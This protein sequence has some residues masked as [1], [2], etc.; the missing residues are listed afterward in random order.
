MTL[1]VPP[2]SDPQETGPQRWQD[3]W[4]DAWCRWRDRRL[5]D[6]QF[7]HWAA[8]FA[9]TRPLARR[10]AAQLFDLVAGF[11]YSQT[12]L[13][14][15]RL[16][17][18]D[19]LAQGPLREHELARQVDLPEPACRRLLLAAQALDLVQPRS[20]GRWGLGPLG[21]TLVDDQ[22]I[23]AMV[24]HHG[25]LYADL[26]DPVALL[27]GERGP[28]RLGALWSY[29]GTDDPA[30]LRPEQVADY[31]ALM[32]AS[33]PLVAEQVL[34]A[35]SLRH[36]RCL[37]DVG[38]GEGRFLTAVARRA[39]HLQLMLF[40]LPPVAE[41]ARQRLATAGLAARV[42]VTGG[43]FT[44]DALPTGADVATLVRVVH[45][46]DDATAMR[47]LAAVR[48]ALGPGGRL[49]LAEPM[50][51]TPGAAAMGDAYFGFYLLAMGS[52]RAR[53]ATELGRMLHASGFERVQPLATRQPLQT[54]LLSAWVPPSVGRN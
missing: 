24:E 15:V 31:S 19:R 3:R 28:T 47:L 17:L 5:A 46:H 39:P 44:D 51:D 54:G 13:A 33:Q 6:P 30:Q 45:D 43:D 10:R 41:R 7:R 1:A 23:S 49:L 42:S 34:D 52:G 11:V 8:G 16:R 12:L 27:R 35:V 53:S 36:H 20:G 32:S 25:A 9:L 37:L 18:F 14:C 22:A 48:Q 29:A 50:A 2:L 21:A 40:D 26:A 38:G 4:R